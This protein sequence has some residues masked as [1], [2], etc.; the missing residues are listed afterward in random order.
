[1]DG[2]KNVSISHI[3][4]GG[5]YASAVHSWISTWTAGSDRGSLV[6][7]YFFLSVFSRLFFSACFFSPDFFLQYFSVSRAGDTLRV[8]VRM[9]LS[10]HY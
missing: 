3:L 9:W 5:R 7:I 10:D 4:P 2:R 1:M 8:S 6:K